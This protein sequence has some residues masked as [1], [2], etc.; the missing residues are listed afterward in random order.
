[1]FQ[2]LIKAFRDVLFPRYCAVCD[3]VLSEDENFICF[4]CYENLPFTYDEENPEN[5]PVYYRF[6]SIYNVR[7]AGSLFHYRKK[8]STQ[9]LLH[10]LKYKNDKHLG[11]FL[12]ELLARRF[13]KHLEELRD[14]QLVP[15]PLHTKKEYMRVYNQ[16]MQ[17]ALGIHN[18]TGIPVSRGV[19]RRV[20]TETQTKKVADER[21]ELIKS[22]VFLVEGP[23]NNA[24]V[25]DDVITTGATIDSLLRTLKEKGTQE[26]VV[27]SLARAL[28]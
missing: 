27:L 22:N 25:I 18:I 7:F 16:A 8:G 26:F 12:G 9:Q 1:M 20:F 2:R 10:N 19:H 3:G 4:S 5:N 24:I 15:V 23:I 13:R 17:I 21:K 11:I 28:K 14:Y 6:A